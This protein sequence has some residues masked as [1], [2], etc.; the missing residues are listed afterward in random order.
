MSFNVLCIFLF[1]THECTIPSPNCNPNCT[2]LPTTDASS[3]AGSTA[4]TSRPK[5]YASSRDWDKVSSDIKKELD[6]EKPE[7]EEALQHLFQQIYKVS[8]LPDLKNV[9]V[10]SAK[11]M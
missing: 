5:A 1:S 10:E 11:G 7:G 8:A 2:P 3:A 4:G 9:C 6:A